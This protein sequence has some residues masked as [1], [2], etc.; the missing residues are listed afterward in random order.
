MPQKLVKRILAKEYLDI[1][2]LLPETWQLESENR[3]CHTKRPRRSLV[4]DINLWTECCTTIAATAFLAKAPH[5]FMYLSTITKTSHTFEGAAW[6][7]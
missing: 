1:W 3:C 5:L 7:I 6:A 4:T 2:E